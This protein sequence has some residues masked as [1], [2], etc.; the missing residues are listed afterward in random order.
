MYEVLCPPCEIFLSNKSHTQ[1]PSNVLSLLCCLWC[2]TSCT[3]LL[4]CQLIIQTLLK[5]QIPL[6]Y[7]KGLEIKEATE[8]TS[9]VSFLDIQFKFDTNGQFFTRLY[10]KR[11][12]FNIAI[13]NFSDL[14]GNLQTASMYRVYVSQF[15][16]Y[17]LACSLYSYSSP[18]SPFSEYQTIQTGVSK[19][20]SRLA[21]KKVITPC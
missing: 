15:I 14:D 4:F 7:P 9:C 20:L 18:N 8:T 10:D 5:Q 21:F 12:H 16:R 6:I 2:V 3:L 13:I 17:A 11:E 1:C 19:E